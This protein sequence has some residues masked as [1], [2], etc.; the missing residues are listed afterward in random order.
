MK[1]QIVRV[2][3]EVAENYLKNNKKNR[4][5]DEKKVSFYASQMEKGEWLENGEAI[6]MDVNGDLK[7]GQHRL[8]SIIKSNTSYQIPIITGVQSNVMSTIDTGKNRSICDIL[9]LEG[10]LYP[11][12]M[13]SL[14]S[15]ILKHQRTNTVNRNSN[16]GSSTGV[17]NSQAVEFCKENEEEMY[18][19]LRSSEK[20]YTKSPYKIYT[21]VSISFTL[22]LLGG[23]DYKDAHIS[24][25]KNL[26]GIISVEG[27]GAQY[28]HKK[29]YNAKVNR[30]SLNRTW[31]HGI[32][33]KAWNLYIEGDAIVNYIRYDLK[34]VM[35]K[36]I[37]I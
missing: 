5:I 6:I 23:F 1:A 21:K 16:A 8:L 24:F 15:S 28:V 20:L 26:V 30:E 29:L 3:P 12:Q 4:S 34:Q 27:N 33:V 36:V 22:Y 31:L 13:A 25:M 9:K 2:T 37:K 35:P 19:L 18:R 17:S 11:P 14:C 7:D 32:I 10:F